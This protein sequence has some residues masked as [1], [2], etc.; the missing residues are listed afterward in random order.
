MQRYPIFLGHQ[1][2]AVL[3]YQPPGRCGVSSGQGVFNSFFGQ[4][5]FGKPG[6]GLGVE[7]VDMMYTTRIMAIIPSG[8]SSRPVTT[9]AM[10]SGTPVTARK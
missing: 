10:A 4:A 5:V 8:G 3:S 7:N 2:E 9:S 6:T 1:V